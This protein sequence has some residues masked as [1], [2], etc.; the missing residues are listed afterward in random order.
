MNKV[1]AVDRRLDYLSAELMARGYSVVDLFDQ[2]V[3]I[4]VCIYYDGIRDFNNTVDGTGSGV[5]MINGRGKS[6]DEVEKIIE[7]GTYSSLF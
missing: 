1:V 7:K 5:L 2:G 4:D 6:V 3:A